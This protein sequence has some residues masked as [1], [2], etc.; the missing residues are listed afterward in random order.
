MP[1]DLSQS[2]ISKKPL[3]P[4][5]ADWTAQTLSAIPHANRS[6]QLQ[7]R[8]NGTALATIPLQKP[9]YLIRPLTWI[10]PFSSVRRVELDR[11]GLSV[12]DLC[13]GLRTVEAIIEEFAIRHKLS[14]REAQLSVMQFLRELT[15]RGIVAIVGLDEGSEQ[16]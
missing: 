13:D 5:Q 3:K 9:A 10:L 15:N 8:G 12:F 14:F 4:N 16:S 1:R 7:R 11:L 2:P 6:M